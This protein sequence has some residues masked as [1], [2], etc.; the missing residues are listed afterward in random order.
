MQL[1]PMVI[2]KQ[3]NLEQMPWLQKT[4]SS[5]ALDLEE[6][7]CLSLN[8]SNQEACESGVDLS[9]YREGQRAKELW[10]WKLKVW[11]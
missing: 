2:W 4:Y 3:L 8:T 1:I 7:S 11:S 6:S 5:E 9:N 10:A